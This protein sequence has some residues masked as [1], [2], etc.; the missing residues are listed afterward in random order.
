MTAAFPT[1]LEMRSASSRAASLA[2]FNESARL[3]DAQ[4]AIDDTVRALDKL[5]ECRCHA[6]S[7]P[8]FGLGAYLEDTL[9]GLLTQAANV[10]ADINRAL[11]NAGLE[12]NAAID[13]SEVHALLEKVS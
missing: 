9:H 4:A 7:D 3:G 11:D 2:Q 10:E 12:P 6:T 1:R 13:L 8:G 5:W